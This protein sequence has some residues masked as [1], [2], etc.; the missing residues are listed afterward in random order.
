MSV[1]QLDVPVVLLHSLGTDDRLWRYQVEELSRMGK[2]HTP[3]T[4]GHG[5]S[6]WPGTASI[7][8]WTEDLHAQIAGLGP[9]HLVGLSMGG[10]QATAFAAKY[11]E[12]VRTLAIANSFV[13]LPPEIVTARIS[14]AE[15]GVAAS[16]IAGY[17]ET[18]LAQTLTQPISTA[19]RQSLF[20]SIA[21]MSPEAYLGSVHATFAGDVSADLA[22]VACPTLVIAAAD[23]IK[24]PV[25]ALQRFVDG[26]EQAELAVIPAAGHLSSI[27]NPTA[28]NAALL[29]FWRTVAGRPA[30]EYREGT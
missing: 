15:S 22:R 1:E 8:E 2:V 10:M 21:E 4:R 7:A 6:E 18:Y 3:L 19:D 23:D 13:N 30:P 20:E 12:L 14:G 25:A 9:V 29:S 27:E 26:I 28:F 24:T 11:P 5:G 16:G 17:A